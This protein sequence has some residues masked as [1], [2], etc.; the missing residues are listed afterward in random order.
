MFLFQRKAR[1]HACCELRGKPYAQRQLLLDLDPIV[2][3]YLT[4]LVHRR[5]LAW[6]EDIDATYQLYQR[7]GRSDLLAAI[8]LAIELRCFGS[9]YLLEIVEHAGATPLALGQA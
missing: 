7:I 1:T 3:P 2:E 9:E 6:E 8:E 5:P 4:E